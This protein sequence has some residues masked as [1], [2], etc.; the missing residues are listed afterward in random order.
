MTPVALALHADAASGAGRDHA[1]PAADPEADLIE[2]CVAGDPEAFR[3]LV[4]RHQRLAF[5]VALRMLGNRADAEDVTQGA[6]IAAYD[7]LD[8]FDP[9]DRRNA[10][11][12][13]L[14]RIVV[15]R[16]KDVLK[17]KKHTE[18]ALCGEV[19]PDDAM[20]A[21]APAAPEAAAVDAERRRV[22]ERALSALPP[23]YREVIVL[24]DVED[25]PYREIRSIL[26]LPIT[27]LKIRVVR[28]RARLRELVDREGAPR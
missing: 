21:H 25:L 5:S 20:F 11:A 19:A 13:W 4:Q 14:L 28:A 18:T 7:A 27:T 26:R 15:N 2:R 16:A 9:G 3:P 23:R 8:R 24:K 1:A 6:F 12:T 17:S 22:L 10:F